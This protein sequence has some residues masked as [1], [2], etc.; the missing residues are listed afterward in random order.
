MTDEKLSRRQLLQTAIAG[1]AAVPAAGLFAAPAGAEM[2]SESDATAKSLGYVADAKKV[3]AAANPNYKAGP[4]L[5]QLHAVHRQGRRRRRA[6]Q[7]L[8]RQGRRRRGLV[9]GLGAEAGRQARL[10]SPRRSLQRAGSWPC[11]ARRPGGVP[12]ARLSVAEELAREPRP[13][14]A[15]GTGRGIG[16][17]VRAVAGPRSERVSVLPSE[18][19]WS[20]RRSTRA[21]WLAGRT[22]GRAEAPAISYDRGPGPSLRTRGP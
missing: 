12:R 3:N 11:H 14:C 18:R 4:A 19:R 2:L 20:R 15:R 1:L 17:R 16:A 6:L 22:G 10:I 7:H 21:G 5:R 13:A 8:P 9:Q